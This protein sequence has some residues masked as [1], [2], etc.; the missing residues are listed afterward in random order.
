MSKKIDERLKVAKK[1]VGNVKGIDKKKSPK[2][3]LKP[4]LKKGEV[5]FNVTRRF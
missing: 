3:K 2:A 1:R 5:G 4:I